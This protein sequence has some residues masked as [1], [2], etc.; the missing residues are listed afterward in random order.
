MAHEAGAG[1]LAGAALLRRLGEHAACGV[2]E[3]QACFGRL[4]WH[5]HQ[6]LQ[7]QLTAWCAA[8]AISHAHQVTSTS[9]KVSHALAMRQPAGSPGATAPPC[10]PHYTTARCASCPVLHQPIL[11]QPLDTAC[12]VRPDCLQ[13]TILLEKQCRYHHG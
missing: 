2:P 7:Q 12:A 1:G 8:L 6:A 9:S 11:Q 5:C 3:L 10:S 4:L 13:T